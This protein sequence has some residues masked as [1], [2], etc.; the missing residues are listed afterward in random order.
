V[1]VSVAGMMAPAAI[2]TAIATALLGEIARHPLTIA[3]LA[4]V[5]PVGGGMIIGLALTPARPV[6]KR[7]RWAALDVA[8]IAGHVRHPPRRLRADDRVSSSPPAR[9]APPSSAADGPRPA[10]RR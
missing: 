5:G 1:I 3:A 9:W 2:I 8:L 7:G 10:M 6:L 4:G